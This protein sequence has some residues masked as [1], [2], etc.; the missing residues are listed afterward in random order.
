MDPTGSHN[1]HGISP[2]FDAQQIYRTVFG[3]SSSPSSSSSSSLKQQ[4]LNILLVQPGDIRHVI[5]TVAQRLRHSSASSA[6]PLHFYIHERSPEA[7]ARHLLLLSVATDWQLPLRQR[8]TMFL[9]IYGNALVQSKTSK[10]ISQ[11]RVSL[12]ELVTGGTRAAGS[13]QGGSSLASSSSPLLSELV[14]FESLRYKQRDEIEETLKT[15]AEEAP[16]NTTQLRDQRLRHLHGTRYDAR[17]NLADWDYQ[18][19]VKRN[20]GCIHWTQYRDWRNTGVAFEFGDQTYDTPN[21]SMSAY[22]DG[23]EKG[24][25]TQR[26]GFWCD[27]I[28]SPFFSLGTSALVPVDAEVRAS[29][30]AE[31]ISKQQLKGLS[32]SS[33]S[34]SSS[35]VLSSVSSSSSTLLSAPSSSSEG[36]SFAYQLFDINSR[37][38]GSEQWRHHAV[39]LSTY[40]IVSW[41]YELETGKG[42]HM[43]TAHDVYSGLS[44]S[45][46]SISETSS[47]AASAQSVDTASTVTSNN[48]KEKLDSDLPSQPLVGVSVEETTALKAELLAAA[49]RRARTISRS[50]KN[51]KVTFLMGD[52]QGDFI[53]KKKIQSLF[54][55]VFLSSRSAHH[56]ASGLSLPTPPQSSTSQQ[57][58]SSLAVGGGSVLFREILS[59][60]G[61]VVVCET[62]RNVPNINQTQ[63][64]EFAR[65]V[66]G[67]AGRSGL[68]V[69]GSDRSLSADTYTVGTVI[70]TDK[71]QAEMTAASKGDD[72]ET[73]K[74]PINGADPI[75]GQDITS[76]APAMGVGVAFAERQKDGKPRMQPVRAKTLG[77]AAYTQAPA[78]L[79]AVA[80]LLTPPSLEPNDT[81]EQRE[82]SAC[83]RAAARLR[84]LIKG[85]EKHD[86]MGGDNPFPDSIAFAY[87]PSAASEIAVL[88]AQQGALGSSTGGS[89]SNTVP[90]IVDGT[91]N[92]ITSA[93]AEI[94]VYSQENSSTAPPRL[95]E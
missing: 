64:D 17:T 55:F 21:R 52:L 11:K 31:K 14:D 59:L 24:L 50:L 86:H 7:I 93:D 77:F 28:V 68:A 2:S 47:A 94:A 8:A 81:P 40:N 44:E 18:Q 74:T 20:A 69:A 36:K 92:S 80:D 61:A 71:K 83:R 87:V 76:S 37:Q 35:L 45:T 66:I 57:S 53:E 22:V 25:S 82:K 34:S 85:V 38:S 15:W 73:F 54:H 72:I 13:G 84:K 3:A 90:T 1:F 70:V 78:P 9:D 29:S 56:L 10:Y 6:R 19:I 42:Y 16:Y 12:I 32:S 33:S 23:K 88:M 63:R 58:P 60:D 65:R 67:L 26:R 43:R 46:E 39:E 51:V 62:A 79:P 95:I 30:L 5:K 27:I 4:P 91:S 48:E 89:S 41:L 49:Q 75:L